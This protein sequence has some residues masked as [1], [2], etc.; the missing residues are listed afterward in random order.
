MKFRTALK[1][2]FSDTF[3]QVCLIAALAI[4]AVVAGSLY[5][6]WDLRRS[7]DTLAKNPLKPASA[8]EVTQTDPK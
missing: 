6:A 8:N 4:F 3:T 5:Y 1:D 2:A 7:Y